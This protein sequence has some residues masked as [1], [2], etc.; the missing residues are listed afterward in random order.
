MSKIK[1]IEM[2]SKKV[3]DL[4]AL[5]KIVAK[6]GRFVICCVSV[7]GC[8]FMSTYAA[9]PYE[10]DSVKGEWPVPPQEH[11]FLLTEREGQQALPLPYRKYETFL[12]TIVTDSNLGIRF[13]VP[14]R[15]SGVAYSE[16]VEENSDNTEGY[17]F[18]IPYAPQKALKGTYFFTVSRTDN[19]PTDGSTQEHWNTTWYDEPI[20]GMTKEQ[21]LFIWKSRDNEDGL[22]DDA[23]GDLYEKDK[24][25]SAYWSKIKTLDSKVKE[26]RKGYVLLSEIVFTDQPTKKFIVRMEYPEELDKQME[27]LF[28]TSVIPFIS[29]SEKMPEGTIVAFDKHISLRVPKNFSVQGREEEEM[30]IRGEGVSWWIRRFRPSVEIPNF[31]DATYLM[32]QITGDQYVKNL[33][34]KDKAIIQGYHARIDDGQIGHVV[35]G[36]EKEGFFSG[37]KQPFVA[38]IAMLPDFSILVSYIRYEKNKENDIALYEKIARGVLLPHKILEKGK[39]TRL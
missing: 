3:V 17:V 36:E 1:K 37:E 9:L 25:I 5:K 32:Q 19:K 30:Y 7:M 38:Y 2:V 21:F 11:T 23:D 29:P 31:S 26:K 33:A 18:Y 12:P 13:A 22:L 4:K 35:Y 16:V 34:Y 27:Y 6:G 10:G 20:K 15:A 39:V 24:A 28:S 14:F 8:M